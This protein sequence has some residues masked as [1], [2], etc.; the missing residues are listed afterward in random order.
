MY[1]SL[2]ELYRAVHSCT[3]CDL[4]KNGSAV[5]GVGDPKSKLMFIGEA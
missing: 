2:E 4:C 5:P 1:N 3:K